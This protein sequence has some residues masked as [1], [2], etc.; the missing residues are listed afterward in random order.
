MKELGKVYSIQ[1]KQTQVE[2]E[3]PQQQQIE[4]VEVT[5]WHKNK[6]KNFINFQKNIFICYVEFQNKINI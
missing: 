1:D 5:N 2:E 4:Q 3:K 6:I